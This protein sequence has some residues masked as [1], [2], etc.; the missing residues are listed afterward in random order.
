MKTRTSQNGVAGIM[1]SLILNIKSVA[2]ALAALALAAPPALADLPAGYKQV[3]YIEASGTQRIKTGLTPACTDTIEMRIRALK[4]GA[5]QCLWCSRGNGTTTATFTGFLMNNNV[6]RFDRNGTTGTAKYSVTKDHDYK[7]VANGNSL[8]TT[9]TDETAGS[10]G[11]GNTLASGSFT[12]GSP[13]GLLASHHSG[14]DKNLGNYAT[15]R[16]YSFKVT[17]SDGTVKCELVP[18]RRVSDAVLGLYDVKRDQFLTNAGTGVFTAPIETKIWNDGASGNFSVAANWTDGEGLILGENN[19]TFSN[20]AAKSFATNDVAMTS[21]HNST[22]PYVNNLA[23]ENGVFDIAA[24]QAIYCNTLNVG[25]NG[26]AAVDLS[27]G[28]L[29]ASGNAYLGNTE[30]STGAMTISGNGTLNAGGVVYIGNAAG[31]TGSMIVDGGTVDVNKQLW[32]GS[33]DSATSSLVVSNGTL[34]VHEMAYVGVY[35]GAA[36]WTMEGG[37]A[38]LLSTFTLSYRSGCT[39][40]LTMNGGTLTVSGA[41]INF[42]NGGAAIYLNGGTLSG[43]KIVTD[44]ANASATGNTLNINGGTLKVLEDSGEGGFAN[45][46][47]AVNIGERGG[48][49]DTNGKAVK[50]VQA[51]TPAVTPGALR[52]V[53]GGSLALTD[54]YAGP[55]IVESNTPMTTAVIP[56]SVVVTNAT[57]A[58]C[59]ITVLTLTGEGAD[60]NDILSRCSLAADAPNT[61]ELTADGASLKVIAKGSVP[62][63][64]RMV[65]DSDASSWGW[66]FSDVNGD[67][68]AEAVDES[69]LEVGSVTVRFGSTDELTAI[70]ALDPVPAWVKCY[71]MAATFD[72]V[73]ASA[74]AVLPTGFA[75]DAG[76]LIDLKGCSWTLPDELK[77]A[78]AAFTVTNSVDATKAV[79]TIEVASGMTFTETF[80]TL[81]GNLELRKTGEGTY[82]TTKD[83]PHTGG[84]VVAAGAMI[85]SDNRTVAAAADSTASLTID[86]GTFTAGADFIVSGGANSIGYLTVNSGT[87]AMTG[88]SRYLKLG[89]ATGA[90]GTVNLNGGELVMN[91]RGFTAENGGS[92]DVVFNGGT[93]TY[94][95]TNE[96][97]LF[98]NDIA[99]KVGARGGTIAFAA[100][101]CPTN[102]LDIVSGVA[103]GETDGGM[104]FKGGGTFTELGQ[105]AYNGGTTVEIGT[106]LV[107]SDTSLGGGLAASLPL[108]Q[109]AVGTTNILVKTTG[110]GVFTDSDLPDVSTCPFYRT[111]LSE[112]AKSILVV[113]IAPSMTVTGFNLST[114]EITLDFGDMDAPLSLVVAW[115]TADHGASLGAWPVGKS[116]ILGTVAAGTTT[117]TFALPANILV[118]GMYYRLF[119]GDNAETLYDQEVAWIQPAVSGAY[120]KTGYVPVKSSRAEFKFNMDGKTYA[121]SG[122][123][124]IVGVSDGWPRG[125]RVSLNNNGWM[126]NI[127]VGTM[128]F[129]QSDKSGFS[130]TDDHVVKLNFGQTTTCFTIDGKNTNSIYHEYTDGSSTVTSNYNTYNNSSYAAP[131]NPLAIWANDGGGNPSM[132]KI[133]YLKWMNSSGTVTRDYIPVVKGGE[134]CLYDK[135]TGTLLHNAGAEGTSFTGGEAVYGEYPPVSF[136]AGQMTST[137][138]QRYHG[139]TVLDEENCSITMEGATATIGWSLTQPGGDSAEIVAVFKTGS[140]SVT[141]VIETSAV[142]EDTDTATFSDVYATGS[143]TITL[144]ARSGENKSVEFTKTFP[145]TTVASEPSVPTL[146]VDESLHAIAASGTV[147]F[148]SGTTVAWLDYGA[149]TAYGKTIALT[150]EEGAWT[151]TIP[152][153]NALWTLGKVYVRV[154]AENEVTGLLGVS[155]SQR[156]ATANATFTTAVR[157]IA[158]TEFNLSEGTATLSFGG[159]AIAA[160]DLVVAW[161]DHDYGADIASWPRV[162]RKIVGSVAAD[163]TTGTF[164]LPAEMLVA[165][166]YYRFFLGDSAVA[167]YDEEVEWI[168]PT[169]IGAY[170]KTSFI[171][172][173]KP[174]SETKLNLD[175]QRYGSTWVTLFDAGTTWANGV[176]VYANQSGRIGARRAGYADFGPFSTSDDLTVGVVPNGSYY[177]ISVNGTKYTHNNFNQSV[178]MTPNTELSFW[179]FVSLDYG[180]SKYRL[181]WSMWWNSA[182]SKLEAHFIPVKKGSE[183]G[184]YD[185]VSGVVS[186][187]VGEEGSSFTGGARVGYSPV[188]FATVQTA[189]TGVR[190]VG[191]IELTGRDWKRPNEHVTLNWT[192]P[193]HTA[194]LWVAYSRARIGA[195][196][197]ESFNP[198]EWDRYVKLGDVAA[199]DITGT[200]TLE[201]PS[202][203]RLISMRFVLATGDS[204]AENFVPLLVSEAYRTLR[205][206]TF[207]HLK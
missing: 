203:Q 17:G 32:V 147:A 76:T 148:G 102:N 37:S 90:T 183:Y 167:P 41:Q 137:D 115:D 177:A 103:A 161:G 70:A 118:V 120:M 52:V 200:Y 51:L 61:V 83:Q 201:D 63:V 189:V 66:Q 204:T 35:P 47:V 110:D 149:T 159:D 25:T 64:A 24:P 95:G 190:M 23:F 93:L 109:P 38:T 182:K 171:P 26:N 199:D 9:I 78:T 1:S 53:G 198:G 141:N 192:A 8:T 188:A 99:V 124:T 160:Q 55:L 136:S 7:I 72:L 4:T 98:Q 111:K 197:G 21:A 43:R 193:G 157:T 205:P 107:I 11:S 112:D 156:T 191:T 206:G 142:A 80:L 138:L 68:I 186:M 88:S 15:F 106:T 100:G 130:K 131:N 113:R 125:L 18:A 152:Y 139:S 175:G 33:V 85:S 49:I 58:A 3:E 19:V 165:G 87:F 92:G 170:I 180:Y 62:T 27:N 134:Y 145:G 116:V 150:L 54:G 178:S 164:E 29:A 154:T 34:T 187:N 108:S 36:S 146:A 179:R 163:A 155:K 174:Q 22:A 75:V 104:M 117:E 128:R 184:L 71:K 172:S 114:G 89:S 79:L 101:K 42:R 14:E 48:T 50:F 6:F 5:T 202:G 97:P 144:F 56:S 86:G 173:Q 162:S 10:S 67:A 129:A 94:A 2:L 65:Y 207:I 44:P 39:S 126:Q 20:T 30:N 57:L 122:Y 166:T 119:L 194:T 151:A 195:D 121:D 181:Y 132:V 127:R 158:L 28:M 31:A 69:T 133:Y 176:W 135:A 59:P 140:Q 91:A 46:Q 13:L 77:S 105:L 84:T 81:G 74:T 60:A 168:Q 185:I 73:S 96:R 16:V 196:P 12:V 153:D 169:V 143:I 40:T 123:K 45:S 82:A